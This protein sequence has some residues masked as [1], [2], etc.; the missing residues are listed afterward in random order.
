M[1]E[2]LPLLLVAIALILSM[3][4]DIFSLIYASTDWGFPLAILSALGFTVIL[5][6]FV[7]WYAKR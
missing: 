4:V 3:V 2:K 1:K 5:T 7:W 6:I